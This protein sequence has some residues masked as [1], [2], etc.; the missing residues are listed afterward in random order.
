ML[1]FGPLEIVCFPKTR[2]LKIPFA[3]NLEQECDVLEDG[4]VEVASSCK[5]G[6]IWAMDK[7]AHWMMAGWKCLEAGF[8]AKAYQAKW[9]CVRVHRGHDPVSQSIDVLQRDG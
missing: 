1:L 8:H 9:G 3:S 6:L 7:C 2:F 5:H 4:G